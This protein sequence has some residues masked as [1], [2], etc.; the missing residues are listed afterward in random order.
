MTIQ[1]FASTL[2]FKKKLPTVCPTIIRGDFNVNMVIKTFE[3][4][5]LQTFMNQYHLK[6]TL[7]ELATIYD[8]HLDHIW[9]HAPTQ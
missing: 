8:T 4:T 1:H 7:S 9:T 6:L 3:S 5:I 2:E